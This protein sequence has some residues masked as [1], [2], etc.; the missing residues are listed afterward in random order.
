MKF[1]VLLIL[2]SCMLVGCQTAPVP[3]PNDP[4]K[5]GPNQAEILR[6]NV[7][8]ASDA[9]N[10]RVVQGELSRD[11]AKQLVSQYAAKLTEKLGPGIP[12][13]Q[14]WIYG[15]MYVTAGKWE[16]AR[17]A[18]RIAV[19]SAWNEDRRVNDT[20]RLA[21]VEARLGNVAEAIRLTRST[22]DVIPTGKAPILPAVLLELTP[23]AEG[24]GQDVELARLLE[25]AIQQHKQ[26]IVDATRVSGKSFFI[27]R[28]HHIAHA[29]E[30]AIELYNRA[31]R[32]DLAQAAQA[33]FDLDSRREMRV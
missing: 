21:V 17:Q 30:K 10:Q 23:A 8:W 33:K 11:Q 29:W 6:E 16:E 28:P 18:L 12:A 14:A 27:A 3:D 19:K 5:A 13:N 4:A 20:L 26:T 25:E 1:W 32:S 7:E 24:K 15:D 2:A 31:G 22:F 9:A